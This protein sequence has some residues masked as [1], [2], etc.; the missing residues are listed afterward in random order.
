MQEET[1][2]G[3]GGE[4]KSG[5]GGSGKEILQKDFWRGAGSSRRADRERVESSKRE[6]NRVGAVVVVVVGSVVVVIGLVTG[7]VARD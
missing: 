7:S 5:E 4:S 6:R 1:V 2:V 3:N